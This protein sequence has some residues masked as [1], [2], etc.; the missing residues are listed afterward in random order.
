MSNNGN[1]YLNQ[2]RVLANLD[3]FAKRAGPAIGELQA[4][5]QDLRATLDA[6]CVVL[7][8]LLGPDKVP[9]DFI[10]IV[11]ATKIEM[12]GCICLANGL[13]EMALEVEKSRAWKERLEGKRAAA[14]N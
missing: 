11:I 3:D 2:R 7:Q 14:L 4:Y 13:R 1:D 10:Q 9:A 5:S 8:R 12:A 6:V